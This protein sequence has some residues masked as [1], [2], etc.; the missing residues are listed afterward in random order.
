[1]IMVL[2]VVYGLNEFYRAQAAAS[3]ARRRFMLAGVAVAAALL[4]A[5]QLNGSPYRLDKA[6]QL[7]FLAKISSSRHAA[8]R[9]STWIILA[10]LTCR[11]A[12]ISWT[13]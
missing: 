8:A 3:A 7:A 6:G 11:R 12:T 13:R 5:E 9:R 1:M 10:Q 2:V 4:V